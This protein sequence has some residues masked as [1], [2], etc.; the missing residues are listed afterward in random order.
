[1]STD[2]W[3]H[4]NFLLCYPRCMDGIYPWGHSMAATAPN[5]NYF[6]T[7]KSQ[8]VR[9]QVPICIPSQRP[10]VNEITLVRLFSILRLVLITEITVE[11]K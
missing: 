7:E 4:P 1:M 9:H 10:A 5:I 6:L 8:T 3:V 11:G 2:S